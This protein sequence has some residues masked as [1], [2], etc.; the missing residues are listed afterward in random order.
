MTN[1]DT[2]V[3]IYAKHIA[4]ASTDGRLFRKTVMDEIMAT[5]SCSL[6]AAATF[7]NN[8][9]KGAPVQGLGRAPINKGVRKMISKGV[10]TN[11]VPDEECFTVLELVPESDNTYSVGRME[12]FVMQGDASETFDS[13]IEMWPNCN[14]VLITGL[15]PNPGE[16]FR[17]AAGEKEIKRYARG[18]LVTEKKEEAIA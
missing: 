7:Y 13:K 2:A 15:G 11:L 10:T 5:C 16:T 14:W 9:K 17:L 1:K 4:L 3:T 18:A 12:S 6:A 8:A